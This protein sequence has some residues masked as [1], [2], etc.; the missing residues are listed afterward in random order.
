MSSP[1]SAITLTTLL[2]RP[3]VAAGR[4]QLACGSEQRWLTRRLL[5]CPLRRKEFEYSVTTNGRHNYPGWRPGA[6]PVPMSLD[7][8]A[9]RGSA[10]E[11]LQF[12]GSLRRPELAALAADLPPV[13]EYSALAAA[14]EVNPMVSAQ[15]ATTKACRLL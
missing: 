10:G 8:F 1:S 14:G 3:V 11:Y 5:R 7:E 15:P 4:N 6:P 13:A 12:S 2:P 9:E